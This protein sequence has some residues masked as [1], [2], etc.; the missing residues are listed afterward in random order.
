[1]RITISNTI[2]NGQAVD[3]LFRISV[4]EYYRDVRVVA[5]R[6]PTEDVPGIVRDLLT[7]RVGN[8]SGI[9][10]DDDGHEDNAPEAKPLTE[11]SGLAS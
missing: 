10:L 1:M 11:P 4:A 9:P 7:E 5:Y 8:L 6:A 3:G 2:Q